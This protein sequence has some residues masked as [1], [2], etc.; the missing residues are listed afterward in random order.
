MTYRRHEKAAHHLVGEEL[1]PQKAVSLT[2][3][4]YELGK[5]HEFYS[6]IEE[7]LND[8]LS[9]SRNSVYFRESPEEKVEL[10]DLRETLE[11]DKD[12]LRKS[13]TRK[14]EL[15]ELDEKVLGDLEKRHL[16]SL[17]EDVVESGE[18]VEIIQ[19]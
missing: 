16:Q 14:G 6:E 3:I 17:R 4:G 10:S 13:L 12:Y 5:K 7:R 11:R 18:E 8:Y 1:T 9:D 15:E 2:E 19:G